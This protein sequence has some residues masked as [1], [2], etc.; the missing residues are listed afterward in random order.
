M[1]QHQ[2]LSDI[3]GETNLLGKFDIVRV[4]LQP[5]EEY[6]SVSCLLL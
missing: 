2:D 3:L 5:T 1:L 4:D 6:K